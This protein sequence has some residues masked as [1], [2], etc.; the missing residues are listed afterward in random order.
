M[1]NFKYFKI[2]LNPSYDIGP[3]SV[4]MYMEVK[5]ISEY[6]YK[7]L[8]LNETIDSPELVNIKDEV[9]LNWLDGKIP[10]DIEIFD[11][12]NEYIRKERIRDYINK[13]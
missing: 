13:L 6:E 7:D 11:L 2:E 10:H 8:R 5:P 9:Y 1:R 4:S 12:V 3:P